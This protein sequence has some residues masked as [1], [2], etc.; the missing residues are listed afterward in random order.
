MSQVSL[1]RLN[2]KAA[3]KAATGKADAK[4]SFIIA[5]NERRETTPAVYLRISPG[6]QARTYDYLIFIPHFGLLLFVRG[7][8]SVDWIVGT[9]QIPRS[10]SDFSVRFEI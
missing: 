4:L 6:Q 5:M 2:S 7:K 9:V 1:P 3:S 8:N 10:F